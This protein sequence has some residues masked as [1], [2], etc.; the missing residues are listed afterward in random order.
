MYKMIP[1]RKLVISANNVRVVSPSKI[2]DKQLIASIEAN[3]LIQN[4]VVEEAD[5]DDVFEVIAGGRRFAA[6]GVL[7]ESGK[8][9]KDTEIPCKVNYDKNTTAVSLSENLHE[10]MHPADEFMAF[11]KMIDDGATDKEIAK[12]FGVALTLVKRR[13][14]LADVASGIVQKYRVGK[15]SLEQVM[16]F[17]V[18]ESHEKQ[19]ECLKEV[20]QYASAYSIRNFLMKGSLTTSS[21]LGK[22]VGLAAYKKAGG[23]YSS[24]LF[25]DSVYLNDADLLEKLALDKL[26]KKASEIEKKEGWFSVDFSLEGHSCSSGF[27][28]AQ[29][30]LV[31][32][33]KNILKKVEDIQTKLDALDAD[34]G[35]WTDEKANSYDSLEKLL[36]IAEKNRDEYLQYTDDHKK[37]GKCVVT[38]DNNGGLIVLRG[39]MTLSA[40]KQSQGVE[41]NTNSA[42][43]DSQSGSELS[44]AL[45]SDLAAYR[46][47]IAQASL[48]GNAILANDILTY[49]L[50]CRVLSEI[51][52]WERVIDA[53]F[54]AVHSQTALD[55]L[56]STVS[57]NLL[58]EIYSGL[59][60]EWA[61][62]EDSLERFKSFQS[63]NAQA[64]ERL[65]SYSVA[66]LFPLGLID[67]SSDSISEFVVESMNIDFPSYWRPTGANFFKRVK[68]EKLIHLGREWFGDKWVEEHGGDSKGKLVAMFDEFF[69][70]TE[71]NNLSE[72]QIEIRN[73]WMPDGFEGSEVEQKLAEIE[74]AA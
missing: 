52:V 41:S 42:S 70:S 38:L 61:T 3:G 50:C 46:Q 20:G 65:V 48:A 73:A 63:M 68:C 34:E 31:G 64:K 24:D 18:E 49:S 14:K 30:T 29:P 43:N 23:N 55:D 21:P 44:Q 57:G 1:Y 59:N 71:I 36:L 60:I 39:L 10:P 37:N 26:K 32:V 9:D 69:S 40:A 7:V 25:E 56:D 35:E 45:Q 13:L 66:K 12:E 74:S 16:A 58:S 22:F 27:H 33:P 15:L 4:L 67:G 11:K 8:L 6:I 62:I 5:R 53:S 51:P 72:S 17:T 47:Q 28:F 19:L 2:K 54:N